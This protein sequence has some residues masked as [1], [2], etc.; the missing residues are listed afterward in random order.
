MESVGDFWC[1]EGI[2]AKP[3]AQR[4]SVNCLAVWDPLQASSFFNTA[5]P[6]IDSF[7]NKI[8]EVKFDDKNLNT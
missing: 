3:K 2:P 5:A 8:N 1:E 6:G 7:L 4:W